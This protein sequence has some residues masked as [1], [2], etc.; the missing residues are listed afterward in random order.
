MKLDQ[1]INNLPKSFFSRGDLY[2][3]AKEI[4]FSFK[5]TQLK[6]YISKMIKKCN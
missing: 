4:D 2:D 3:I 6:S 1:L 5:E